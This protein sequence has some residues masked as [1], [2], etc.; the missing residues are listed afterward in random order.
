MDLIFITLLTHSAEAGSGVSMSPY[1]LASTIRTGA[2]RFG[3]T[4]EEIEEACWCCPNSLCGRFHGL[5]RH[6]HY[7]GFL[8]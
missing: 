7:R 1:E 4:A 2:G 5:C 3:P 6:D 8:R